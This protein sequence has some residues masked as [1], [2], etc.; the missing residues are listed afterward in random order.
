MTTA[1]APWPMVPL[2]QLATEMCLGKMLDREKN[3]GE[4]HPYLRNI[5]VRWFSFDLAD[6]KEMRFEKGE[7][8][9]YELRSGDLVVCEGGEP[10]RA[11]VWTDAVD[12]VK[13]QKALHRIR[14]N[15]YHY[16]P[17]FAAY[18]LYFG[19]LTDRFAR[20]YTGT[21]IKHLTG[22]ALAR[23][24]FPLPPLAEQ[25]RI[26]ARVEELFAELD[27]AMA[28]LE[29]V[30]ANL[31]RYRSSVLK[32][33]VSGDLTADW[34]A[35]HPNAEP[36]SALLERIL[37]DRR[38]KWEADQLAKLA[39][40][41]KTPPKNWQTKYAEPSAPDTAAL[42]ELPAGWCW[43]TVDQLAEIQGGI[44][45]QPSRKPVQNAYPFLRVANV[46]RDRLELDEVHNIELF[47]GELAR[48]RLE[49]GDILIVEGN[50][51]RTEIGR[52]AIWN[53]S[54]PDCVHQNH[55]I[56]VRYLGGPSS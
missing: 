31:K 12:T 1:D 9:R 42:P 46:H 33:A 28:E 5:N 21:T 54:I 41:N 35:T 14:F 20:Y 17:M 52:S 11:A 23:I 37:K 25:R 30:R 3:R 24:A 43:A 49:Q 26:V 27:V 16:L 53:G 10:G 34:Q 44:Q 7:Q 15:P 2:S 47:A 39:A 32:A 36:A 40:D 29:Q 6:L 45:K 55:I 4:L 8:A 18:F 13:I 51:S 56:R 19:T 22:K 38:A 48:L 50:G